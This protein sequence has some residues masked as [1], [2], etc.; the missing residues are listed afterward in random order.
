MNWPEIISDP[1]QVLLSSVAEEGGADRP[2]LQKAAP[3]IK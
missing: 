3:F 2:V 1:R